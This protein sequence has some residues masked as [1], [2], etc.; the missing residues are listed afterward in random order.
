MFSLWFLARALCLALFVGA[1]DLSRLRRRLFTSR[2][3]ALRFASVLQT[4]SSELEAWQNV[5]TRVALCP[6]L[7]QHTLLYCAHR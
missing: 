2:T 7:L 4:A 6:L 1:Y 3:R 5:A